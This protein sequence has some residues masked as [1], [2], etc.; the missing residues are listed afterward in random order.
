VRRAVILA[1]ALLASVLG[2]V[3]AGRAAPE[4]SFAAAGDMGYNPDAAASLTALAASGSQFYLHLGDLSY[5]E[6]HPET[7]WCDFV[8]GK[9]GDSFPYEIVAGGHDLGQ[10]N[11]YIDQFASCLPDHLGSNGTYAKQYFFDYPATNPLARVLMISPSMPFR[12][13]TY[14]YSA[15]SPRA[16]WVA[17]AIDG[18]RAA[19]IPWVFVGMARNCISAGEKWCEIGPDLFKLLI[20]KRVDLIL[21]AHE[22]GY[23][24][25]KQLTSG[26]SCPAIPLDTYDAACVA[27][28]GA[29]GD[30][31]KGAG[32]IVVV[33]GTAGILQRPMNLADPEAPYFVA[34]EGSNLNETAGFMKY[35]VSAE[36]LTGT[37]VRSAKGTF[38]DSFTITR[39]GLLDTPFAPTQA[40]SI[41][42]TT[43]RPPSETTSPAS[44]GASR[45]GYWM[46]GADGHVYPFGDAGRLGDAPPG[47]GGDT[48]DL[49][50]TPTGDGYWVLDSAGQVT[51]LG[52]AL[53]LGNAE[54]AGLALEERAT[55][56]SGTPSGR[57]YWIFTTRGRVL[58]FGDAHPYGDMSAVALNGPV[59]D[60]VATPSGAGYYMVASDGGVFA[61]GDARFFGSMGDRRLNAPVRSLVPDGDGTG[62]WLVATDGGIF[63]F[64]AP[65]RGSMGSV[66]VN[67]PVRGMVRYGAGYVM[68]GEDGGIFNFSDR[69]YAGSLGGDPPPRPVVAVA[70]FG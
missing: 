62:Y 28:D 27:D 59:L 12:E 14:D 23:E 36:R 32:P 17:D 2:P 70:A 11:V 49:E 60:S 8:K 25:S 47:P 4:F 3:P 42:T 51:A 34:L 16:Q 37:F 69:P 63:A 40:P 66:R 68:V 48:V 5:N 39:P 7:A 57:G 43:T 52:N 44:V 55:S 21:Q 38:A 50:P 53:A 35:T 30:H 9:V 1:V 67:R 26:P 31:T 41:T 58:P 45:S 15:G 19:H 61:F 10:D 18:A 29:D 54:P 6:M 20:D 33:D 13:E 24:R 65:F 22:H 64:D 56:L 46:V